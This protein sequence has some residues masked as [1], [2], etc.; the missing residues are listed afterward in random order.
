MAG[1][2]KNFQSSE[3][4]LRL[5]TLIDYAGVHLCKE[6]LHTKEG[7]TTDGAE[8]YQT[9]KD[10]GIKGL[11]RKQQEIVFPKNG[12]TDESKFD[13]TLYTHLIQQMFP[14]TYNELIKTLRGIRNDLC[15]MPDKKISESDFEKQWNIICTELQ[16]HGFNEPVNELKTGYLPSIE[17]VKKILESIERQ[18]QGRV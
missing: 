14:S 17:S 3:N 8:L 5:V 10:Y 2:S 11:H 18:C 9:F 16:K 7:L 15:H 4:W 13:I 6:V 1:L 12:K